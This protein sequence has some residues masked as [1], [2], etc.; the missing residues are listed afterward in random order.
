MNVPKLGAVQTR[1]WRCQKVKTGKQTVFDLVP[2]F[3][4]K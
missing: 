3:S 1:Q 4:G 2:F